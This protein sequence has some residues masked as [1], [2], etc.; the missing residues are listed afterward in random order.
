ML[1]GQAFANETRDHGGATKSASHLDVEQGLPILDTRHVDPDVVHVRRS[2]I[3]GG[4]IHGNLELARQPVEFGVSGGPLA[5]E[6]AVRPCIGD[7]VSRH[8]RELFRGHVA[9]AV[10]ARLNGVHLD[11]CQVLEDVRCLLQK[12]PVELNILSRGEVAIALVVVSR[13]VREHPHLPR[14]ERAV[15]NRHA[16]HRRQALHVETV[17]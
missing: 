1:L 2:A 8:S 10:S 16:Q 13:D 6:L 11:L 12:G 9:N 4:S 5:D 15:R 7:L 14:V 17:S 3:G